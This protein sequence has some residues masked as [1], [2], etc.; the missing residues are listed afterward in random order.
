MKPTLHWVLRQK[1]IYELSV[2]FNLVL[3]WLLS[4][5][6]LA[7]LLSLWFVHN[8]VVF[9]A[10]LLSTWFVHVDLFLDTFCWCVWLLYY[11]CVQPFFFCVHCPTQRILRTAINDGDW[12]LQSMTGINNGAKI[13][14]KYLW[15]RAQLEDSNSTKKATAQRWW[16]WGGR[17]YQRRLLTMAIK[18]SNQQWLL[19]MGTD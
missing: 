17:S 8:V 1:L 11:F 15:N 19:T 7:Y 9:L 4:S 2:C 14:A 6:I 12:R 10:Y 13:A 16:W 18:D 5:L 3:M